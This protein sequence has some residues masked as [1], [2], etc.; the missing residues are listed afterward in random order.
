MRMLLAV[1]ALLVSQAVGASQWDPVGNG[2]GAK[3][4]LDLQSI[5]ARGKYRKAWIKIEYDQPQTTTF[6]ATTRIL[7]LKLFD[8]VARTVGVQ[9]AAAYSEDGK[10]V[11][12]PFSLSATQV[13]MADVIPDTMD[14]V[15]MGD[16]C[17]RRL[18]P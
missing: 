1:V 17:T 2:G 6:P 9:Q 11:G 5:A 10:Q 15:V 7:Q 14:E 13:A 18:S 8:C 16:V 3:I 12:A 4:F